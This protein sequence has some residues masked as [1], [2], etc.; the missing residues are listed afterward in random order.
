MGNRI[1]VYLV[2][3]LLTA[4]QVPFFVLT[5]SIVHRIET[6]VPAVQDTRPE[7]LI[8]E[9]AVA[10]IR[11]AEPE[12][13]YTPAICDCPGLKRSGQLGAVIG[14]LNGSSAEIGVGISRFA[15][16]GTAA[17]LIYRERYRSHGTGL[18]VTGYKLG[19]GANMAT[20]DNH[21]GVTQ[22][23]I[24]VW[25]GRFLASINGQSKD[26]V[27]RFAQFLVTEMSK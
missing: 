21:R 12:W 10:A 11:N 15:S 5:A 27:E 14:I 3:G 1:I 4:L 6:V 8:L 23:S 7:Q 2:V 24:A 19:D 22:Y 26:A 18:I 20:Y 25:K 13:R 16:A 9:G 17:R